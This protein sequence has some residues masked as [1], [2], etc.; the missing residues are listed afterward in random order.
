MSARAW[1]TA[2]PSRARLGSCAATVVSA[3][4][5]ESGVNSP[6]AP[7]EY[8]GHTSAT[9]GAAAPSEPSWVAGTN[10]SA[11]SPGTSTSASIGPP[12]RTPTGRQNGRTIVVRRFADVEQP[13]LVGE[14]PPSAVGQPGCQ[15][16]LAGVRRAAQHHSF[17]VAH[18]RRSM[19]RDRRRRRPFEHEAGDFP[20][21]VGDDVVARQ[22]GLARFAVAVQRP[23][24]AQPG[25]TVAF[26][27]QH[28]WFG[29]GVVGLRVT[30]IVEAGVDRVQQFGV[31]RLDHEGVPVGEEGT[32]S[33][34]VGGLG[35]GRVQQGGIARRDSVVDFGAHVA[36]ASGAADRHVRFLRRCR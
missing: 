28:G 10:T 20:Q 8:V 23:G 3:S 26:D 6:S 18:E 34:T 12:R 7:S 16:A 21:H 19:N 2:A 14:E 4:A 31:G 5:G 13:D 17:S 15:G 32:D 22:R 11:S 1:N 36:K 9:S 29:V 30:E 25:W 27:E 24:V 35:P 33:T